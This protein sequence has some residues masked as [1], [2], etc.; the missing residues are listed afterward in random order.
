M[1]VYLLPDWK[2]HSRTSGQWCVWLKSSPFAMMTADDMHLT[3]QIFSTSR[4]FRHHPGQIPS[5][6]RWWNETL[7]REGPAPS[8]VSSRWQFGLEPC[9]V[10]SGLSA[11][12]TALCCLSPHWSQPTGIPL[13]SSK[14]PLDMQSW[15][16]EFCM[17]LSVFFKG[18]IEGAQVHRP[19]G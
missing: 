16:G 8:H 3:F 18:Q 5:M 4:T 15:G 1:T 7:I 13:N 2:Q 10:V 14:L 6:Y 12:P 19:V 17:L 11:A 9:S